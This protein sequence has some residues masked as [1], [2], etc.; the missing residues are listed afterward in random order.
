MEKQNMKWTIGNKIGGLIAFAIAALLILGIISLLMTNKLKTSVG[1]DTHTYHVLQ[2]QEQ[3]LSLLKDAETGQRGYIITGDE[4]YLEPY[5]LAVK[6]VTTKIDDLLELTNDNSKQQQLI[7]NLKLL[8]TDKF[9]EL[10]RSIETRKEKGFDA[11]L[12]IVITG[13]GKKYMDDIRSV[14]AES[15]KVENDLLN[16][17]TVTMNNNTS[18][19]KSIIIY[20]SSF[21]IILIIIIGFLIVRNISGPLNEIT[22]I[23][24]RIGEGDLDV[25]LPV[26]ERK[27]EV[28]ILLQNF[29][30]MIEALKGMANAAQKIASGDITGSI[31][32]QSEKDI[33]G[34]AFLQMLNNLR[35]IMKDIMEGVNLLGS[36]A[37]EILAATT[38][39]ASGTAETA[40]A[41]SETT[42]TV[43]E[44]QQAAKQTSQK[45]KNVVESAQLVAKVSQ[46]GQKAVEETVTGMNRIREQ[47]DTIAQ[48]V[49]RLSE[50]SQSIG[51][52]IASVTD[53]ADQ[54]NLLA[55]NAAIEAAK[56][57]EQGK[58]FAVVAQEIKNLAGQSKQSTS[59][60]RNILNDVQKATSAA[61]LATEQGSKA[62]VAGVKQSL[63]AGETIR[64]LAESIN[65]AVQAATQ[66]VASSQQQVVG[67]DQ[68][69]VAM[70]NINQAGTETAVSMVQSEK[71]AKNLNELGQKLKELVERFKV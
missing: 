53:I 3:I 49:V 61:V 35:R 11:A 23:A 59:Q 50:Q 21:S 69:G 51:G 19:T 18:M 9:A 45:A 33:L 37:S 63:E 32:P 25:E 20:G 22:K 41:I 55:V 71:A 15:E 24:T 26:V 42:T 68:I 47:M 62:V 10:D 8:V 36:S 48:T 39:V 29:S 40:T 60:I 13:K 17:R 65:E 52:I 1:W 43:E 64:I 12:Q 66:I 4:Q 67:M 5:N 31:A 2:N 6:D 38:Q 57:G 34:N 46:N 54:S 56:A 28:G 27:D 7:G 58:G 16:S 44:V 14:M 70:Q 30:S